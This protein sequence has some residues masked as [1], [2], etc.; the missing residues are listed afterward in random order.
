MIFEKNSEKKVGFKDFTN[1]QRI[2]EN[3]RIWSRTKNFLNLR[4]AIES[5]HQDLSKKYQILHV[6]QSKHN[7]H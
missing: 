4:V 7:N 2:M 6:R 5:N 1:A 3:I